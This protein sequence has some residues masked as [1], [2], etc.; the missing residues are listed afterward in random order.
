M[1]SRD[2]PRAFTLIE[3]LVVAAIIAVLIALLLPA[4]DAAIYQAELTQC[5]ANQGSMAMALQ[6]YAAKHQRRYPHRPDIGEAAMATT[7]LRGAGVSVNYTGNLKG[8]V[9]L[10]RQFN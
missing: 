5:G 7:Q 9:S 2:N 8:Y 6:I 3:L 1:A 10:N 4:L